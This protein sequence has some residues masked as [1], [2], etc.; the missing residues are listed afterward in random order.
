MPTLAAFADVVVLSAKQLWLAQ[1]QRRRRMRPEQLLA[2][3]QCEQEMLW[4]LEVGAEQQR[5]RDAVVQRRRE[6]RGREQV[7]RMMRDL[8]EMWTSSLN[9]CA[10]WV[11]QEKAR[12]EKERKLA[13]GPE[14]SPEPL[15]LSPPV[16]VKSELD[17]ERLE[18]ERQVSDTADERAMR[19]DWIQWD[20][21]MREWEAE[22]KRRADRQRRERKERYRRSLTQMQEK[23]QQ[24]QE[25]QAKMDWWSMFD[26]MLLQPMSWED[27]EIRLEE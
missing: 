9:G 13:A 12:L 15:W 2:L 24:Q 20:C 7:M 22:K 26:P 27:W 3:A 4:L 14:A 1:R 5:L 25:M 17:Q 16:R 23:A 19:G 18:K 21:V 6:R 10:R 8:A 11:K